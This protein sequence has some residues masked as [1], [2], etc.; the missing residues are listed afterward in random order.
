MIQ[1][2]LK[3]GCGSTPRCLVMNLPVLRS[4]LS[5]RRP[6]GCLEGGLLG[7]AGVSCA[8]LWASPQ[9]SRRSRAKRGRPL[10]WGLRRVIDL[11]QFQV[12]EVLLV[13]LSNIPNAVM[14]LVNKVYEHQVWFKR[15]YK[16]QLLVR[17]REKKTRY[18]VCIMMNILFLSRSGSIL[19]LRLVSGRL[20]WLLNQSW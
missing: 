3:T 9:S 2:Q 7:V 18:I 5:T 14:T 12:V 8:A 4:R 13:C 1:F 6:T 16:N 20:R 11:I 10:L 15:R 19:A 17:S